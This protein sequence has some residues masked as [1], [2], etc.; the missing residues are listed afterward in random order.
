MNSRKT[1]AAGQFYPENKTE[2]ERTLKKIFS[3]QK[4]EPRSSV[5][6]SP[7][8]G[9]AYSGRLAAKSVSKLKEASTVIILGP[10]HTGLGA[11]ISISPHSTWITP[12]GEIP[13]DLEK[14][15]E[16]AKKIGELDYLAHIGE[17]SI[18]V[19]LPFLQYRFKKFKIL[20]I[21]LASNNL[22][23]LLELGKALSKLKDVSLVASGDFSHFVPLATAREKD[24]EAIELIEKLKAEEFFQLVK[25]NSLSICGV[26]PITVAIEFAQ[27][28]GLTRAVALEY[29]SSADV[30]GDKSNVVGYASI[31]FK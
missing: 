5:V 21:T 19:I 23:E 29:A 26:A 12:L 25:E 31:E 11:P 8:A 27:R 16:I 18:E 30:T 4:I 14:A 24:S 9:Y 15:E 1:V 28:K 22:E 13:V 2:L 7:H 6:I 3:E 10:N 17:H 20:P